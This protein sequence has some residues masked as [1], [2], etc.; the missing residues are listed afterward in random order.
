MKRIGIYGGS[1]DPVHKD[2][3]AICEF[4]AK[5]MR[6]DFVYV[7]PAKLSPFKKGVFANASHR[8]KM[9]CLACENH[10]KLIPEPFEIN[11]EGTNYSFLTVEHL[12]N[13]HPDDSLFFLIGAD[14]LKEFHTWKNPQEI[15]SHATLCVAGRE[16]CDLDE[17]IASFKKQFGCIPQILNIQG[18][19]SST[20][21]R[22][23]L[24]LNLDARE[25][26][27]EKVFD[28]IKANLLYQADEIHSFL[29]KNCTKSR[30]VHTVG[31]AVTAKKYAQRLGVDKSKAFLAG[32]LHDSAKYL[33]AEDY[34]D[35]KIPPNAPNSIIH[36]FLGA[37]IAE[38]VFGITDEQI[39][40]AIKWHTTGRP[41]MSLLDKIVFL[42]DLLEPS[43]C[44][45]EVEILRD[46]VD[47]DFERGFRLCLFELV[48]FLKKDDKPIYP[49]TEET[50]NYYT[51]N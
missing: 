32:I 44:F 29:Q 5:S 27:D 33:R 24:M 1:F 28:Y 42:A 39:L 14:S 19:C 25:F 23:Y 22:E 31:V 12:K 46:A 10:K 48:K 34:P 15:L 2:H 50:L 38:N 30:L 47:A 35:C 43:R 49:L 26:L 45:P 41:N 4:F 40:N 6:L 16:G 3:I 7:I 37:Y 13:R 20:V 8:Y 17:D 36:Q 51:N 21:I 11:S 9:V 18:S